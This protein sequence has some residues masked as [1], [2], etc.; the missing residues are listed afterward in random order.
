M[1]IYIITIIVHTDI[2]VIVITIHH[3]YII[4][5]ITTFFNLSARVVKTAHSF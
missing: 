1:N 5:F 3:I 4:I 2:I